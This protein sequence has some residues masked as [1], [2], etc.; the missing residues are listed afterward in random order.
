MFA[1]AFIAHGARLGATVNKVNHLHQL[2]AD[3]S[4]ADDIYSGYLSIDPS[5]AGSMEN[6]IFYYFAESRGNPTTDPVRSS[7]LTIEA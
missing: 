7:L 1:L 6:G 2:A 5:G 3:Q 4:F